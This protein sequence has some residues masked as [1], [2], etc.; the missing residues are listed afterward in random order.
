MTIISFILIYIVHYLFEFFKSTLTVPKIKDLVN[1]PNQNYEMIH[2][3]IKNSHINSDININTNTNI[4]D[5]KEY[6][7]IDSLPDNDNN[8]NTMKQDLKQFLKSQYNDDY[9]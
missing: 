4:N 6:S 7:F 5:V 8:T 2:N 3:I 1:T 9:R